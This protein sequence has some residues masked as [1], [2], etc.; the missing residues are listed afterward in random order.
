MED[1]KVEEPPKNC[2]FQFATAGKIIED[3]DLI[4]REEADA[5]VKKYTEHLKKVW[6]E[7]DCPE[8]VIWTACWNNTD[9]SSRGLDIDF[10][11]CVLEDG[12]FYKVTKTRLV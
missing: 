12:H 6:N 11:D 4:T 7:D 5:L 3:T 10:R 9:Y 2:M 8:M 1:T